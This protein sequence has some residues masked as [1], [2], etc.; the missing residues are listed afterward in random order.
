MG[1]KIQN[2]YAL[3]PMQQGMLYQ[4]LMD[5]TSHFYFQQ[6]H[7]TVKATIDIQLFQESVDKLVDRYDVFRTIF[8][9]DKTK[10][11]T[12][13]VL[14][15]K[16][17]PVKYEDISGLEKR[18][19]QAYVESAKAKDLEKGFDLTKDT[20]TRVYL[21][22]LDDSTFDIVWSFHH[23][24]LDGWSLP[25][26][27]HE[28]IQIY[29]SLRTGTL[30]AL[31]EPVQYACYIRWLE[32][33]NKTQ[34]MA[35]WKK[36]LDGLDQKTEL[37]SKPKISSEKYRRRVSGFTLPHETVQGL[38]GLA[39]SNEATLS[40]VLNCIWAILLQK[41]NNTNDVVFG[42]VTSGRNIDVHE[43]DRAVG[44]LI[45]TV[46]IRVKAGQNDTFKSLLRK[47]RDDL[48]ENLALGYVGLPSIQNCTGIKDGLFDNIIAF[49]NYP[50]EDI[51]SDSSKIQKIETREQTSYDIT[52]TI[53]SRREL[54]IRFTYNAN[55]YEESFI[56]RIQGHII[57]M[58]HQ[59]LLDETDNLK[60]IDIM[61]EDE[62]SFIL[63]GIN[64]T[65]VDYPREKTVHTLFEEQA[66]RTPENIALTFEKQKL[67]YRALN[68][69]ANRL[70]RVLREKGVKPDT[71]VAMIAERSPEMIIGLLAILKAG[72]A[73]LPLDP[74]YPGD[75]IRYTLADSGTKILLTTHALLKSVNFDG[76]IID[77]KDERL[78]AWDDGNL[79]N[80]NTPG[81]L[82]YIIYTS[83][84]TGR[85]KGV[86][87]EHKNIV[88][89]MFNERMQFDFNEK[90][91]WTMF[92]SYCFD[93]SVWEMYGALL[94][95]GRLV[96]VSKDTAIDTEAYLKLLK[97]EKV[98]VLNQIPT[99]FYSLMNKELNCGTRVLQLRYVIF[100]GE[101]LKPEMLKEWI[102]KYPETKL[103]NMYGITETTVH[104]TY[105]EIR[106]EEI[107]QKVSNIGK[108]IPTLTIYI[109]DKDLKLLPIGVPGELC[110]GGEGVGRG[111]LNRKE[112]TLQKF[113]SN[114]YKGGDRIYK[115]GDLARLL[116]NG[117]I[118]YLGRIDHQVKIRGFR[119][120]LGEIESQLL[121]HP[122]VREAVVAANE[123]ANHNKYLCAYLVADTELTVSALRSHL[124]KVL[125]EYM[126][127]S[128]FMQLE[129]MPLTSNGKLDRKHLSRLKEN[130]DTGLDYV[131]PRDRQEEI[132]AEVW[133]EVLSIEKA[134]IGIKDSFFSIGGDS[135]RAISLISLINKALH[136]NI[137]IGDLYAYPTIEALS[138]YLNLETAAVKDGETA[139]A[140]RE[141]ALFKQ[142]ILNDKQLAAKLPLD[143]ED[144][145]PMS[146]IEQGM[147]YHST[148]EDEKAVYHDQLV[149]P[150]KDGDFHLKSF[151]K[152]LSL[153]ISK[154]NILRTSFHIE[155]F[156]TPVQAVRKQI[157]PDIKQI[158]L[159]NMSKIEQ[160]E[161]IN[162]YL[163]LDRKRHFDMSG[164]LWRIRLFS[165]DKEK[166]YLILI[167][168]HAILDG[169]SVALFVTELMN[170]YFKIKAGE[171]FT[172]VQLKQSYKDFV[173]DQMIVKKDKEIID[174]WKNELRDYKRLNLYLNPAQEAGANHK[175]N[176]LTYPLNR[177]FLDKLRD[178]A[179]KYN[180][181]VKTLCFAAYAYIFNM[182][183]YEN[184]IVVGLVENNRPICDNGDRILGCFLNTVPVRLR[185]DKAMTWERLIKTVEQKLVN[186]KLFGRLPLFEITN[187]IGEKSG[188]GNSLFDTVFNYMDFHIY[189][190]ITRKD[191]THVE[192]EVPINGHAATNT[193]FDFSLNNTFGRFDISLHY[194]EAVCTEKQA[195]KFITYFINIL[196][197]FI[198]N[199]QKIVNKVDIFGSE[200]RDKLLYRWNHTDAAYP[201]KTIHA[202]FEE[203]VERTPD[204]MAI[205][206]ENR[207]LTYSALNRKANRLARTLREKGVKPESIVAIRVERSPEM[208]IGM[209][210]ILKAGG[211][212][213]PI[214]PKYPAERAR[215]MLEDSRA[216]ILLT[217]SHLSRIRFEGQ[218][219]VMEDERIYAE[220]GENLSGLNTSKDLAYIIYTSGSTGKPKGVMVE[221]GSIAM[222]L[223]W[224]KKQ[225]NF[226][227][228]DSVLQLFS[229]SF[230]AFITS[231]YTPLIAGAKVVI[232]NETDARDVFAIKKGIADNGITHCITVPSIC[233]AMMEQLE[234][235]GAKTLKSLTLGGETLTQKVVEA[236]KKV[237]PRIEIVNEYGPTENSVIT[238]MMRHVNR[239]GRITIGKPK[240]NTKIYIL[241]KHNGLQP[242]G[243]P[244]EI[245]ISGKG[246]ARGY[247][248]RPA[249]T[250]EKFVD[251]PY[252]PGEKM[253]RSGDLGK[254]LSDGSI[255]FLG[256]IDNQVKIRGFRIELG[257][258]ENH[259]LGYETIKEAVVVDKEDVAGD[260]YLC[261][262]MAADR[263]IRVE[264]LKE[265]LAK[266][267]P[268][269]MMPAY[270]MQLD[271][272]PLT[273]NGKIDRKAL[274]EKEAG[275][276][277]ETAYE[278][279]GNETEEKLAEI[280]RKVLGAE[281]VGINDNF[282]ELGGHSLKATILILKIHKQLHVQIPLK[283]L[284]KLPTVKAL[285]AYIKNAQ[286][287]VFVA[288]DP[289]EEKDH[290]EVSPAQK[291]MYMLQQFK[292]QS[293]AYNMPM[294][295]TVEGKPDKE[296]L[297]HTFHQL[298]K[299][300]DTLRTSFEKI[301]Q[302][303]VQKVNKQVEFNVTYIEN[304]D[305]DVDEAVKKFIKPF[306]LSK[307]PLLR[308]GLIKLNEEKY[309]L[310][311]D[312]HH[313]ISDGIS[314]EIF[315][316][317]FVS[318]YEGKVLEKLR[319]QYKDYAHWQHKLLKSGQMKAQEAYWL[320]RFS[321]KIPV[322]SIE[323]D[324]E[325]PAIKSFEGDSINF[326]CDKDLADSL[327]TMAKDTG[328]TLYMILL[329]G[330][331]IL[332]SKYSGQDDII[333]GTTIAG[334]PHADLQKILGMFV[335]TL[336]MRTGL[337]GNKS[338]EA[339]L[340]D[341]KETVLS[342]Y[343]NQDYQFEDL[344]DRLNL[345]RDM[346]RNPLFDVM[347]T[348]Q[349]I[350]SLEMQTEHLIFK[351]YGQEHKVAKF[352]ITFSAVDIGEALFI[353]LEYCTKLFKRETIQKMGEHYMEI[354]KQ[355]VDNKKMKLEEIVV[356]SN[357]SMAD[358]GIVDDEEDFGF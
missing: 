92:H 115:S 15:K 97:E 306:D 71:I 118:E 135:I 114:P 226:D 215:H 191:M 37:C 320:N 244:G 297:G 221:H 161:Y 290:Y 30:P 17:C 61:T 87:L 59:V 340:N 205:V 22:K 44:L 296:K 38:K 192:L 109:M 50:V 139:E 303:I 121:A 321:G 146:S 29:R 233:M 266:K 310:M 347:F 99:P 185:F 187:A 239:N 112:L 66:E 82:A 309:I 289:V 258:I 272:M 21:I 214:D 352:D 219:L 65:C 240:D 18:E 58:I 64:D 322:L 67:T 197:M 178:V 45:N 8:V 262:Y 249:L 261:A 256:R 235:E 107:N 33:R 57:R 70:A 168:H 119:I 190:E 287:K 358:T 259:L 327:K 42:I 270:F 134:G 163:E 324:Y 1:S 211:A 159:Q 77:L 200:E 291:R 101:A 140:K 199:P 286:K 127:P 153:M 319:T 274:G 80:I 308:A 349:N 78:N 113:V 180:I 260:R 179:K 305:T 227:G 263:E 245:C 220:D 131:G 331:N 338:Y 157:K 281:R 51:K 292:L 217:Q 56:E 105:K 295:M 170:I 39:A 278:A 122:S 152:A 311:I 342:A 91:V 193:L 210:A 158:D 11:P 326:K 182:L 248:N 314:M 16:K 264:A 267:L 316:H 348:M 55:V 93:F 83:G 26:V 236:C 154:H 125:P 12:Q 169:W 34:A 315:L 129:K 27:I 90:D 48:K 81:D 5:K 254:W 218:N 333:I 138:E 72:G 111:Y 279:P 271:K 238:T 132:L 346:S 35:Y 268:D 155:D 204:N 351:P 202:L 120:E 223:Q 136:V 53:S 212:Y 251:N 250:A 209:L 231:F 104:V 208:A 151:E 273:L 20:L 156:D 106:E 282:F 14:T 175:I 247:L 102:K 300:H 124:S 41:Y 283:A 329:S 186:L 301:D 344:V 195:G 257:E 181:G 3:S 54:C 241:D 116:D 355:V 356:E 148:K 242:I 142:R 294:V 13:V 252:V 183:S 2:M 280:W 255:A 328:S 165:L 89:L 6:I 40:H 335:N 275:R 147:V 350:Q 237:H 36:Y 357:L 52:V 229:N 317:E 323:T 128:Y 84:T 171:D 7:I 96:L 130:M 184:D 150:I 225:Y 337:A 288:I 312:M 166:I 353:E 94:F 299:R 253:Y 19:K 23:I 173:L 216:N 222:T 69:R 86:M 332:L 176:K 162:R 74:A 100:G 224:R 144:F 188:H 167:A 228:G 269:Y 172:Q 31:K 196:N 284:F 62:K 47:I 203:Q 201:D 246:L 149:Y 304:P 49:E 234:G 198:S 276:A 108:S 325:R 85:P 298:I 123:D 339:F 76:E 330:V 68:K 230:D 9:F 28:F 265:Y 10:V 4:Y 88:R 293:V 336:V 194:S 277:V 137:Q 24:I 60:E 207:R 213:L 141:L 341:I 307:A 164:L 313:I 126:I 46:P 32:S 285:S 103:V 95:G 334:R 133:A 73:Y 177:A 318:I 354:L 145:Y 232:L 243:V 206:F 43:M 98:T 174:Y 117:D 189:E 63:N 143:V 343:D 345:Q 25:V 110:V 160:G 75:R 302:Q 79:Q